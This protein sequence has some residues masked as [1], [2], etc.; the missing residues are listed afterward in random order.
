VKLRSEVKK[1]MYMPRISRRGFLKF[2]SALTSA[3]LFGKLGGF[4][5]AKAREKI[6]YDPKRWYNCGKDG[7]FWWTILDPNDGPPNE[8]CWKAYEKG[9]YDGRGKR[10]DI[11]YEEYQKFLPMEMIAT[12]SEY[13]KVWPPKN[14][15]G[16]QPKFLL[17]FSDPE[18]EIRKVIE[19]NVAPYWK[20]VYGWWPNGPEKE[21]RDFH[22]IDDPVN[23]FISAG[24]LGKVALLSIDDDEYPELLAQQYGPG[25]NIFAIAIPTFKQ[26]DDCTFQILPIEKWKTFEV[27]YTLSEKEKKYPKLYE[28]LEK[29]GFKYV[30]S[31]IV[32]K[33]ILPEIVFDIQ[34]PPEN[35]IIEKSE[36]SPSQTQTMPSSHGFA[37]P[38]IPEKKG[39]RSIPGFEILIAIA[40][41]LFGWIYRR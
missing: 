23:A 15:N 25:P 11:S 29:N 1:M 33:D 5:I 24:C 39:D 36:P 22:F 6:D 10:W 13:G 16:Y 14:I 17:E 2:A 18:E 28:M 19:P 37:V 41:L 34:K 4:E 12:Q 40:S 27:R 38:E 35:L 3:Y 26:I 9:W 30:G 21:N 32:P 7:A 8:E 20:W 31:V